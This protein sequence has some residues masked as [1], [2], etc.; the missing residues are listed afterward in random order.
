VE[1]KLEKRTREILKPDQ[2]PKADLQTLYTP[3]LWTD[4]LL[5]P[6]KHFSSPESSLLLAEIPSDFMTLK[7]ADFG[8]ASTWRSFTRELFETAFD[9][10]Y[11]VTDFIFERTEGRPRSLYVLT[12]GNI[13]LED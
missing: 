1:R 13:S 9:K 10:K 12:D 11:L 7:T 6:P 3:H 8:L 4:N 5:Q 2:Y